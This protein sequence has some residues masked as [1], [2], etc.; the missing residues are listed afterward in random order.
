MSKE[1]TKNELLNKTKEELKLILKNLNLKTTGN[2]QELIER[3]LSSQQTYLKILPGDITRM[4]SKYRAE[5]EPN[6]QLIY[7]LLT[8]LSKSYW[9][10]EEIQEI[11][12]ILKNNNLPFD[13]IPNPESE[14]I[15]RLIED[16]EDIEGRSITTRENYAKN[17]GISIFLVTKKDEWVTDQQ[18]VGFMTDILSFSTPAELNDLSQKYG[19]KI[20]IVR[21]MDENYKM[22]SIIGYFAPIKKI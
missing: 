9:D 7:A 4:V 20:A 3:I 14:K 18:V 5:N 15:R 6:N 17:T 11:K 2:K 19:C 16:I 22:S 1:Y 13:F 12:D 10:E 21:V 8:R